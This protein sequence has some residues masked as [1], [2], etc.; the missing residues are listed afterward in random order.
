MSKYLMYFNLNDKEADTYF[1]DANGEWFAIYPSLNQF[2]L[3]QGKG[4]NQLEHCSTTS[5][6]THT[7]IKD[8]YVIPVSDLKDA[9][10]QL[11]VLGVI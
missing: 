6:I 3:Y 1:T 9:V 8:L 11:K 10:S 7:D 4:F 2:Q 5:L